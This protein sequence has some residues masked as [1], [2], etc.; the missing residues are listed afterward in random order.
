MRKSFA[1]ALLT[2]FMLSGAAALLSA[3]NTTAGIGE[4]MSA[5]G[6]SITGAADNTKRRL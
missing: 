3:C 5:A 2:L 6:R 1:M 4:D